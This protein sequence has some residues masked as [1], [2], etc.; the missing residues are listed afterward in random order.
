M[1]L[2]N[3]VA[4]YRPWI[5]S[6]I[7]LQI[8]LQSPWRHHSVVCSRLIPR[9]FFGIDYLTFFLFP[10]LHFIS[11]QQNGCH[12]SLLLVSW[13]PSEQVWIEESGGGAPSLLHSTDNFNIW[14]RIVFRQLVLWKH[15]AMFPPKQIFV[16]NWLWVSFFKGV[17]TPGKENRRHAAYND[18]DWWAFLIGHLISLLPLNKLKRSCWIGAE[19]IL[20]SNLGQIII[21]D[22]QQILG[23]R[24]TENIL[25]LL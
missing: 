21:L 10:A 16:L 5:I 6:E 1:V 3:I 17:K 23:F 4:F 25:A 12:R 7:P 2:K 9:H 18:P 22:C 15:A 8:I 11:S 14:P 20:T 24:R 19:W 13:N